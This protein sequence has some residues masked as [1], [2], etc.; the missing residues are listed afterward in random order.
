V[1]AKLFASALE[2]DDSRSAKNYRDVIAVSVRSLVTKLYAKS[3]YFLTDPRTLIRGNIILIKILN[4]K[5]FL[6]LSLLSVKATLYFQ[7]D[8][9]SGF[10]LTKDNCI[11]V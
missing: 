8:G 2:R 10:I 3:T 1:T 4:T 6:S 11:I 9:S 5:A 7:V